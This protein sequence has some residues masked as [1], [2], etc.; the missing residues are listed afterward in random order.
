[1]NKV[2]KN[3]DDNSKEQARLLYES[4]AREWKAGNTA[5][6][7]SLYSQSAQLDP[8]GPG[9]QALQMSREIMDFFDKNQYN[10]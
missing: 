9:A 10:P 6:A 5:K 2:Q 7:I 1:M 4:G 3:I 8:D